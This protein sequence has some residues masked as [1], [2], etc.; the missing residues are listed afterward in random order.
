MIRRARIS[1]G[2]CCVAAPVETVADAP[3]L[4]AVA[5]PEAVVPP[6][7][8]VV[9]VAVVDPAKV[10]S[11]TNKDPAKAAASAVVARTR[12]RI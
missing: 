6:P 2:F 8:V 5:L 10:A 9:P 7:V 4:P 11:A 12:L 1:L 3:P